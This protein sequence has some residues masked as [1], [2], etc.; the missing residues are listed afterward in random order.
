M[1]Q[2]RAQIAWNRIEKL[3]GHGVW[4]SDMVAVSLE[5]V[6][7]GDDDLA[8]F[9]DFPYIQILDLSNNAL[10]DNCLKHLNALKSLTSLTLIGTKIS[11]DAIDV[12]KSMHPDVAIRTQPIPKETI[13]PWTGRPFDAEPT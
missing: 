13:N 10:T 6:G 8:L 11:A 4:E 1:N 7:I 3:G 2:D 12:F 5:G 9:A